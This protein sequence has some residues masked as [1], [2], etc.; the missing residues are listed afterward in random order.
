MDINAFV[1]V[2][3]CMCVYIHVRVRNKMTKETSNGGSKVSLLRNLSEL[4]Q[5]FFHEIDEK[6]LDVYQK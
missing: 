1:C 5:A 4:A 3:T 6:A 2:Y